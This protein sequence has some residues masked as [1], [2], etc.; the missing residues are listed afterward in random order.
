MS[1][2]AAAGALLLA[3]AGCASRARAEAMAPLLP[4]FARFGIREL[5]PCA[6]GSDVRPIVERGAAAYD[7]EPD[8][9][10][11][12]DVHH[13]PADT[14]DKI[15]PEDLR[16]NAAAIALLAWVLAEE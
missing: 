12:F 4:L 11:Y 7:L 6:F 3:L 9:R 8:G 1:R 5:R 10:G 15:R 14:L 16:R 2:A 13:T